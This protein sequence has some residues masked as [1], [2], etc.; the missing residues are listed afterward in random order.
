MIGYLEDTGWE[1]RL[2][3]TCKFLSVP[4]VNSALVGGGDIVSLLFS[5]SVHAREKFE[6]MTN[7]L[8]VAEIYINMQIILINRIGLF[9]K[10]AIGNL[11]KF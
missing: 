9:W 11:I 4:W 2:S 5:W 3:L 8:L 7:T 10:L 1:E 6:K